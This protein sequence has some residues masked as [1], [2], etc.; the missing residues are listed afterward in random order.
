M[1]ALYLLQQ[2][3][4]EF[5][6]VE[7]PQNL[8][9]PLEDLER[10]EWEYDIPNLSRQVG[11]LTDVLK[12]KDE[13]RIKAEEQFQAIRSQMIEQNADLE[14]FRFEM[15]EVFEKQESIIKRLADQLEEKIQKDSS[16]KEFKRA[17]DEYHA[18][19][20]KKTT[21]KVP[22]PRISLPP[23]IE[24]AWRETLTLLSEGEEHTFI[25]PER[26]IEG[27]VEV[28]ASTS[29]LEEASTIKE[30]LRSRISNFIIETEDDIGSLD[31]LERA[32]EELSKFLNGALNG[33]KTILTQKYTRK[34]SD[35]Q[36]KLPVKADDVVK[37]ESLL[38]KIYNSYGVFDEEFFEHDFQEIEVET[39]L[40]LGNSRIF[41]GTET[42]SVSGLNY[43]L[44]PISAN[45]KVSY[46]GL[47]KEN[48]FSV[49]VDALNDINSYPEAERAG[50][51]SSVNLKKF[52]TDRVS[53]LRE[54]LKK[55]EVPKFQKNFLRVWF[56]IGQDIRNR[57]LS[58]LN[59]NLS[60]LPQKWKM[61]IVDKCESL[62]FEAQVEAVLGG[63]YVLDD[64]YD[65]GSTKP[66]KKKVGDLGKNFQ[67]KYDD[68]S[69][70][71]DT[72]F[73]TWIRKNGYVQIPGW[74]MKAGSKNLHLTEELIESE[75]YSVNFTK[76]VS[77]TDWAKVRNLAELVE[78]AL[79]M[80]LSIKVQ[81]LDAIM[82]HIQEGT[83]TSAKIKSFNRKLV[84]S[85]DLD[86][87]VSHKTQG[88][89][90]P[91]EGGRG[92]AK[93]QPQGQKAPSNRPAPARKT[94][95][96]GKG[97][98]K[99]DKAQKDLFT[100]GDKKFTRTYLQKLLAA[101]SQQRTFTVN[102]LKFSRQYLENALSKGWR[103]LKALKRA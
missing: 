55:K 93:K 54:S 91:S 4:A 34:L 69:Y 99:S 3:A 1:N 103:E 36:I 13:E 67:P 79:P 74:V 33:K 84:I 50:L 66:K 12:Q 96:K 57:I 38:L 30:E 83:I 61:F 41:V 35:W 2:H 46:A 45:L 81:Y 9:L 21:V 23:A 18:A 19:L 101:K 20:R 68:K 88:Q 8:N 26:E 24:Q 63:D 76:L 39:V 53:E 49:N 64:L 22:V 58:I 62:D 102:K 92:G 60:E 70:I 17:R 37:V 59:L 14:T 10:F 48:G 29:D 15:N 75:F 44:V 72:L 27:T 86:D 77:E 42:Q 97:D 85:K 78:H 43:D 56:R 52:I 95:N 6:E 32:V 47:L 80:D 73:G 40:P 71:P 94:G 51:Y 65:D 16:E 31:E 11:Y 82:R 7:I 25:F 87:L 98:N 5:W 89:K 90:K 100:V 28:L